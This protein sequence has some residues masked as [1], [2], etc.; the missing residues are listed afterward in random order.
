[1][2]RYDISALMGMRSNARIDVNRFSEVGSNL[3]RQ[4]STSVLSEQSMNRSR[5][6]SNFSRQSERTTAPPEPPLRSTSSQPSDPPCSHRVQNNSG[7][8][9]FLK[10]HTSPKHQRVTAGGRIVPMEAPPKMK[11]P[12]YQQQQK[13]GDDRKCSVVSAAEN[14]NNLEQETLPTRDTA[15]GIGASKHSS[16]SAGVPVDCI[17]PP[18]GSFDLYLQTSGQTPNLLSA[19]GP[20]GLLPSLD[21][22]WPTDTQQLLEP[23][24]QAPEYLIPAAPEFPMLNYASPCIWQPTLYDVLSTPN[25][26][27]TFA[28]S[29]QPHPTI[30]T[31]SD[32]SAGS[33][34]SSGGATPLMSP[35]YSGYGMSRTPTAIHWHQLINGQAGM[36][37]QQ[38]TPAVMPTPL[39]QKSLDDATKEHDNLS[40]QLARL[41]RYMAM[42]TWDLDPQT[43]KLLVEQRVGLVKE[44]DTVRIYREHLE[45]ASAKV[46]MNT[47]GSHAGM[48]ESAPPT[49]MYLAGNAANHPALFG[50]AICTSSSDSTVPTFAMPSLATAF[51]PQLSSHETGSSTPMPL[52]P[53]Q[54]STDYFGHL[55]GSVLQEANT[56]NKALT[57]SQRL[58]PRRPISIKVPPVDPKNDTTSDNKAQG[59]KAN[60]TSW[61]TCT[62][63][64]PPE[65]LQV[66]R[67]MGK[68]ARQ[69]DT[70]DGLLH[71]LKLAA[72]QPIKQTSDGYYQP[73][74]SATNAIREQRV[75]TQSSEKAGTFKSKSADF[76]GPDYLRQRSSRDSRRY[77][78]RPRSHED[79]EKSHFVAVEEEDARSMLSYVSTTDSWATVHEK[80][81]MSHKTEFGRQASTQRRGLS[82]ERSA[83]SAKRPTTPFF[84]I[85]N[86]VTQLALMSGS[87]GIGNPRTAH[88]RSGPA[89]ADDPLQS[90]QRS[91]VESV[92]HSFSPLLAP[93][94]IKDRGL[95]GPKSMA[96]AVPQNVHA[97][98]IL[99]HFAR[100]EDV[101]RKSRAAPM[102]GHEVNSEWQ[103]HQLHD[104][105][106]KDNLWY[107][108]DRGMGT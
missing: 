63:D 90:R 69:G 61:T 107:K 7:F 20:S 29:I 54:G 8:A 70:L 93:C 48:S 91:N 72:E 45:Y 66:Y 3:L 98:G 84:E 19:A 34:A 23:E 32:F 2:A 83:G 51:P 95:A 12:T 74:S 75:T 28:P 40:A 4:H 96:L 33:M 15:N 41:D 21:M 16:Q 64:L 49:G 105:K 101:P 22:P 97:H 82:H 35:F 78:N 31:A 6:V 62:K 68:I 79:V 88:R 57:Q 26:L 43:K 38:V 17:F 85:P 102:T 99:P 11:L 67:Q 14:Q 108:P 65:V 87:G 39:Y 42:H 104:H 36:Q 77:R 44:L 53:W 25:P 18:Y 103:P 81:Y 56:S 13:V 24:M 27:P 1:M 37:S 50:Q 30:L 59:A 92:K 58:K 52:M 55:P 80:D 76:S 60:E 5:N 46:R 9:Q 71:D 100:M 89:L 10:E 106:Q 47:L 86:S 73:S 94:L